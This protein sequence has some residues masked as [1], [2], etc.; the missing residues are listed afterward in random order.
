MGEIWSEYEPDIDGCD[1]YQTLDEIDKSQKHF[2]DDM[3]S[4][5]TDNRFEGLGV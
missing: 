5:N 4:E 3:S 2:D 1:E